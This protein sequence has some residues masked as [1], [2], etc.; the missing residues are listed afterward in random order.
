MKSDSIYFGRQPVFDT[1]GS[2][3]CYEIFYRDGM[4]TISQGIDDKKA[5]ASVINSI[6]N[7]LSAKELLGEYE[8]F[9]NLGSDISIAKEI[10]SLVNFGNFCFEM[11]PPIEY[12]HTNLDILAS[13]RK[14]NISISFQIDSNTPEALKSTMDFANQIDYVKLDFTTIDKKSA[15]AIISNIKTKNIKVKAIAAKVETKE[16]YADAKTCGI[17][18]FQGYF[19]QKP[20]TKKFQSLAPST[21]GIF[22][23]Y[24]QI[25]KDADI[26]SVVDSFRSHPDLTINLLQYVNRASHSKSNEIS[27]IRQAINYMG[28]KNLKKWLLLFLYTDSHMNRYSMSLLESAMIRAKIIQATLALV[29]KKLEEK[30]FLVGILSTLDALLDMKLESIFTD[31]NFDNE[32][33]DALI[34]RSGVLGKALDLSV[35]AEKSDFRDIYKSIREFNIKSDTFLEILREAYEWTYSNQKSMIQDK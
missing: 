28:R 26:E 2:I 23:I 32:I 3:A 30:G 15:Y 27:S 31:T 25:D 8:L 4:D 17:A 12:N 22:S 33:K 24:N 20:D 13:L 11:T 1:N 29:D 34:H 10:T 5:T 19:F 9:I 7:Y 16:K 6:A 14:Q 35:F 18:L 21:K